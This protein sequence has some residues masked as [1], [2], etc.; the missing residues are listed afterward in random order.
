VNLL[1]SFLFRDVPDR[2]H[3]VTQVVALAAVR[4][5]SGECGVDVEVKWPND[6][7]VGG[8]KVAGILAQAAPVDSTGT[9][10]FVVVG[11]GCNIEWA[12]EGATSL[13]AHAGYRAIAPHDFLLA[14]LPHIDQLFAMNDDELH[15][16]Y[17]N[18]LATIGSRVRAQMPGDVDIVGRALD[19]ELD[20][21][22][23]VLDEC[24][25]TH[26]IDTAD[27]V[28]LRAVVD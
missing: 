4:V 20:G 1:V 6:L 25:V 26:R 27:V 22:L 13:S 17:V 9:I 28:H 3:V 11:I 19:V 16:E 23:V 2:L 21:R 24:G 14:M 15:R 5:A 18:R 8:E 12:P 7:L 10:P